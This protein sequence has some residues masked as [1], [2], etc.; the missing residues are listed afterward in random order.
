MALNFNVDPYYDDFDDTK[1]F[2]RILF[3]PGKA[4]QAREL[5]QAQTILQDQ[6]TK[7]ANNIFKE[8]SPVTGGQITTNFDCYY[9]KL[10]STYNSIT[11]DVADFEGLLL[12]NADGTVTARVVATASP[13]GTTNEGDPPTL[14]VVYKSGTHFTDNEVIYDVNSNKACQAITSSSTGASSVVS[15]AKGVFFVLGNFVQIEPTTIILSK[16]DNTPSKR[17]G[18][19]ITETIYDYANDASL[20]DPAVGASNYQA[21]GADRYVISLT[22]TSKPL[23]FGDDQYF[24]ELL[25]VEDGN[26]FKMLDGSVYAVIDDYFAKR[27]FETN[28]DYIVEDFKLTPKENVSDANT[29]IMNVGKGLAYVRGYRVENPAP[30]N[31]VSNRARTTSSINNDTTVINY[32]SYL[33]VSNVVGANGKTFNVTTSNTVDF[34]CVSVANVVTTNTTTYNSTLV[35]RGYIRGLDFQSS[36]TNSDA[37]TYI[38]KAFV[39]DL[40]NQALTGT[41]ISGTTTTVVLPGTNGKT[42]TVDDAYIGVDISITG[43]TNA[44]ETRTITGYVGST[45]TATVNRAWSVTP[46]STSQFVLNFNT[47]DIECVLKANTSATPIPIYGKAKIDNSGKQNS[48]SSGDTILENPD[49]PELIFPIGLPYVSSISDASYTTYLESREVSFTQSS[50]TISAQLTLDTRFKHIGTEDEVLTSDLVEE[51]FTII[52]TNKQSNTKFDNGDIVPW[53]IS[54][55]TI[56]MNGTLSSATLATTSSDLSAFT[57]TIL[58]KVS[59]P[60]ATNTDMILKTKKLVSANGRTVF[61]T[62]TQVDTHTYVDDGVTSN[63]QIYIAA[64]G[65]KGPGVKQSLYLSDVKRIW[66][67][68]DTKASGTSPTLAMLTN[69]T[70]D[71]TNNYYFDNG[72]RDSYYD[73]AS[74]TLKPGAPKPKG[75]LL[76]LVDYYKHSGGDG[77]FSKASYIEQST[78]PDDY[79]EIPKYTSKNGTTYELRDCLDFRPSRVNATTDFSFRYSNPDSGNYGSLIPVDSSSFICDYSYYLGRKD[80]LILTKDKSLQIIEGSPSLNPLTPNEPD[81]SL[82]LAN[83]T[84]K[85]YTSYVPTELITGLSD[86]SVET[87][88]HRRYTMSDIASLDTRINRIEYYTALNVMEQNANSLQISDAYGLNRFKNGI[89]VDDFSGYSASEANIT[90]FNAS[91]NRRTKKMTASQTVK[92]FPLK[93]LAM[94]SNMGKPSNSY[95]SSLNFSKASSGDT[96]YYMLPYTSTNMVAQKLASRKVNL[97]PFSVTNAKGTISLSP[98]VDNWVDTT[99]SPSL[100]ITD[101]N[102]HIYQSSDTVNTLSSGDWQTIPGTTV[103]TVLSS[104]STS[105]TSSKNVPNHGAFNGPFGRVVGYTEHATETTTTT[106]YQNVSKQEQTNIVGKYSQLDNTYSLNNEYVTD[107][108]ILPWMRKQEIAVTATNMLYKTQVYSFFDNISVDNYIRKT[109]EI[110][111]TNVTGTFEPND[112]IGYFSAGSFHPTGV[113]IGVY[114]YPDSTNMRLYVAGDGQTTSYH[115]GLTLQNANFNGDGVYQGQTASGSFASQKHYGGQISVVNSTTSITL[116]ALAASDTSYVGKVL[117]IT[118]GTGQGSYATILTYNG[119]TKV[120]TLDTEITCIAGDIY[121]IGTFVTN[122]EGSFY[123][124]FTIP[125]NTFHTGSRVFRMDNRINGNEDTIT[126][127]AEGTF[128]AQGLQTNKQSIDF[129]ASP[130]GAKDTFTQV[131]KR[132]NV[133]KSTGT[134]VSKSVYYTP[135]DPVAQTFI[136]E[137]SN[138]ANGAYI[139]SIRLFFASKPTQTDAS[140]VTISIVGT[141]NGYPN[142]S[143]LDN[144]IVTLPAY[145]VKVSD[146][147][148]YLDSTTYTEFVF[149]SPVYIQPSVLYAFIVKSNS[150]E[151][152]LWTASNGDTALA[153][154]VKNLSTDPYPSSI[155]K[156]STAPYVGGLFLSQNAQTW[157][158]DQNQSMMFTIERAKF[159]TSKTPSLRMVVPKK[160]PQRTLIEDKV[161]YYNDLENISDTV[162]VTSQT[163]ILVDAFNVTTTDFI[164]SATS[165]SYS[166]SATLQDNTSTSTQY[167]N[168]GKYGTTMYDHIYL[169]DNKGERILKKDSNTSFSLYAQLS[170]TDDA[171]SPVLSDAGT[172]LFAIQYNINNC[173]LA[174]SLISI[175]DGGSS[176][177]VSNTTVA[178]SAPT[179][180]NGQQAYAAAEI[181]AG[182]I[183]KIYFTNTGSGYIETPTITVNVASGS[184]TGASAVIAGETSTDGGPAATRYITKKVVLDAGFDSGDLNVYLTAYR[185]P[186]TDILVYYKILNRNDTQS[187]DDSSWQLM[188]KTKNTDTLYSKTRDTLHEFTFAPG[189]GGIDQGYVS[190]VSKNDNQT[191]NTFNQFAIKI[192]LVT[193]D[194]TIVPYLTDM[195]CIALPSNINSVLG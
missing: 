54:G 128:F 131:N 96:N 115:N 84:H 31:I 51:N 1:N 34:H 30:L 81:G 148:Q 53:T 144:S 61:T 172:S 89:M 27:D 194:K 22:L 65:V 180:K 3:K 181:T 75:N 121:S 142:G 122:E 33:T 186:N 11:I 166:Y 193:T 72:Q 35:A 109:N 48:L 158:V 105:K 26:V 76:L 187:F 85:P 32:G 159:D 58:Y 151:Y 9:I 185:P 18:L 74:V 67:I 95:I 23:Y 63:G 56:E 10:Q 119:T 82:V 176:Y 152:N 99:Y 29:Y 57:A 66:K 69:S 40:Q 136:I 157:S 64:A 173:E 195:R 38:Y 62:G 45:R 25:R 16:Y 137:S 2:H 44:G 160:L 100:L 129:G 162:G 145:Q 37:N 71:V 165:V 83:L 70:Y 189:T 50:G 120:A 43:G 92:N 178:V 102:L 135:Y 143:T 17:V 117:C 161:D 190:Y 168:P 19:E 6:I 134:K 155:T 91:I 149:P 153:S 192:V 124:I 156:I 113:V 126:T 138:F 163:D 191:Y 167:I 78:A 79:R 147:P 77:Y 14:I 132:D 4:V 114:D 175:V 13:T 41:L 116:G 60:N 36:P 174:N 55:R 118:S 46:D 177:N 101:P 164:P 87:T 86:L 150:N 110:E 98:N 123:G 52:V 42:S 80:K 188:N 140:P 111:L 141:L 7:F 88:Q 182:E 12:T 112:V 47:T 184:A 28:G 59:V 183:T 104:S 8:N 49:K 133:T 146:S 169:D 24:I 106:I 125:A 97:N 154:S 5:T 93:N 170:S 15:I 73:H 90:D 127:F 179:G 21:P 130:A 20:L 171:V 68:I 107:I 94:V 39:Y 139:S 103:S 108:S